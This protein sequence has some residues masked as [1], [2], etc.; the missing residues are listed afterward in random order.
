M[1]RGLFLFS[2]QIWTNPL[3]G[4]GTGNRASFW[5]PS[6]ATVARSGRRRKRVT[7]VINP[8]EILSGREPPKPN[9]IASPIPR[10]RIG[11]P[12]D[13]NREA[14]Y[15]ANG[16]RLSCSARPRISNYLQFRATICILGID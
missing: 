5:S 15:T 12:T 3:G 4:R 10:Y 2:A 11:T 16:Q 8:P 7:G 13:G 1:G 6:R 14:S 9:H